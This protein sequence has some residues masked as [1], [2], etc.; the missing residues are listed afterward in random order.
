MT[1]KTECDIPV[2]GIFCFFMWFW[3]NFVLKK[4]TGTGTVIICLFLRQALTFQVHNHTF[5]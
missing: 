2:L 1:Q 4:S 5:F 3:K